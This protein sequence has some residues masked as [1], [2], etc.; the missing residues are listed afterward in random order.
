MAR[1][2]LDGDVL[3]E[4]EVDT[5]ALAATTATCW[6]GLHYDGQSLFPPSRELVVISRFARVLECLRL[7]RLAGCEALRCALLV[8]VAARPPFPTLDLRG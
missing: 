7:D 3:S 8:L 1:N 5:P 6:D 2:V 4:D